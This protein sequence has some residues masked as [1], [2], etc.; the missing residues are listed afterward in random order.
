MDEKDID[1]QELQ[2][3]LKATEEMINVSNLGL[4][5]SPVLG[6]RLLLLAK[7]FYIR[8]RSYIY[9]CVHIKFI[10]HSVHNHS[11]GLPKFFG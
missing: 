4:E 6:I 11:V 9:T 8:I 10:F 2:E 3:R 7:F 5:S 1:M